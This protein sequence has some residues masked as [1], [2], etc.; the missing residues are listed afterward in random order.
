M[1]RRLFVGF[2]AFLCLVWLIAGSTCKKPSENQSQMIQAS[3]PAPETAAPVPPPPESIIEVTDTSGKTFR[4]EKL[5][6]LYT[7]G[8]TWMGSRPKRETNSLSIVISI[9]KDRVTTKEEIDIPF[10]SI[11]KLS[12]G[13][14]EVPENL[15]KFLVVGPP[16]RIEK[17]DGT[18]LL[19]D[20]TYWFEFDATGQETRRLKIDHLS[21]KV[22]ETQGEEIGFD[23]FKGR[24]K[25][26]DGQ[27]GDFWIS[28]DEVRNIIPLDI[29]GQA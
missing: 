28:W 9:A 1:R 19:F 22:G 20:Y 7:A 21:M 4:V 8:G 17:R 16:T 27:E 11:K 2:L 24:A 6:A 5:R 29:P 25:N 14:G 13:D 18:V 12:R 23:G 10:S 15:K 26:S 3:D